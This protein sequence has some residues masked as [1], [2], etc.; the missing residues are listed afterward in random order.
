M[1][2]YSLHAVASRPA[3]TTAGI[4]VPIIR[5]NGAQ[6]R[7]DDRAPDADPVVSRHKRDQER[8]DAHAQQRGD[9]R[10]LAAD[11]IAV[12]AE[13][14]RTDRPPD[15]ADEIGAEGKQCAG[16]RFSLG[17]NS[18]PNTRPAAVP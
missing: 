17:K 9:E 7:Q 1:C 12:M 10:R 3:N 15:E 2:D 18:L 8:A 14:R 11:A 6:D 4:A 16:E 5:K 13:N